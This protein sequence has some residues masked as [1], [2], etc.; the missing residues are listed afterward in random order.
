MDSSRSRAL[1]VGATTFGTEAKL[2][3]L[4]SVRA[5]VEGLQ[6]LLVDPG[7]GGLEPT[8]CHTL[9]DPATP[10]EFDA[11]LTSCANDA[12]DT[13]L[14]YYAGHGIPLDSDALCILP[15][16]RHA[17]IA[18]TQ[19]RIRWNGFIQRCVRPMQLRRLSSWTVASAAARS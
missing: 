7:P 1:L 9:L 15:W 3:D 16:A 2:D 14:V 5:G 17:T 18:C 11:A 13:L 19:P 10:D 6:R 4:P 8:A 12:E